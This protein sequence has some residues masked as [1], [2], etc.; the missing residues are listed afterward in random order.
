[1]VSLLH[2][3]AAAGLLIKALS[4]T[5]FLASMPS[6]M[7]S[8]FQDKAVDIRTIELNI[9]R[10]FLNPDCSN[11]KGAVLLV[12]GQLPGPTIAVNKGDRVRILVRNLIEGV[13]VDQMDM[14]DTA[15][16][17]TGDEISIHFHGIRQVGSVAADGVPYITQDPIPSGS[18]FVHE[19]DLVGQSGTYFYH[20]HTGIKS[21]TV[22]GPF[23][24][25]E[26]P[27]ARPLSSTSGLLQA[28]ENS[29]DEERTLVISELWH[30]TNTD[31]ENYLLG[32]D[33]AGIPEADSVL[34]NGKTMYNPANPPASGCEGYSV[35]SV[36]PGKTI[37]L[38]IIGAQDFRT[39]GFAVA[40]HNLTIIEVDGD[41]VRPFEVSFLEVAPGQRFS[42]LLHTNRPAA[43]Y[44][45]SLVRRWAE[46]IPPETNGA[47]ILRY[48][49]DK[50]DPDNMRLP[51]PKPTFP[52]VDV[53]Y[54]DWPSIQP[55][56]HNQSL[57]D[58]AAVSR[59][60]KLRATTAVMPSDNSTRWFINGVTFIDPAVT[61]LH[62]LA[63]GTR[64]RPETL[65]VLRDRQN[66]G[67]DGA[68]GTYPLHYGEVIDIVLQSTHAPSEPCRSHPWH[69]HGHSHYEIATGAGE[70]DEE[71]DG[72]TRN[73]PTPIHKDVT[74]VYPVLDP[75]EENRTL[76]DGETYGCGWSKI[77]LY[78]DNPGFWAVHC[79]NTPHMIMGMMVVFEEAPE[80]IVA[81]N[82]GKTKEESF[83]KK[84]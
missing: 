31:F 52:A 11:Y 1:M 54:W 69:T 55:A 33:F 74:M 28:G 42:V 46:G 66:T 50:H 80:L 30:R 8:T 26:S 18:V 41:L 70:Y 83:A 38:R 57:L 71:R 16:G 47:A 53:P 24:V 29:Y 76:A 15:L 4:L 36:P 68:L 79:H 14:N 73:M 48:E 21:E 20:A 10:A 58:V 2:P 75:I 6:V 84:K 67:Y 22:F 12:N 60:I 45:I 56:H 72:R 40:G 64:K 59:V 78:A 19:F 63:T 13:A 49:S 25:Y 51:S 81:E 44:A 77:R 82:M 61:L 43:A 35:I 37:R 17:G 9:T 34:I 7:G 39:F 23:L 65:A 5:T 62:D 32:P 3:L 27:E